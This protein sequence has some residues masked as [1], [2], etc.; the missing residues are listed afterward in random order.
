M[1]I[2]EKEREIFINWA[3][4]YLTPTNKINYRVNTYHIREAFM[5]NYAH[6]FY[7]ENNDVNEI[8]AGMGYRH[9]KN[10]SDIYL[11]WNI[12]SKSPAL[13]QSHGTFSTSSCDLPQDSERYE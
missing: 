10:F 8:L 1:G 4:R 5:T 11:D 13:R 2:S 3:E 12:S 6:G 7:L 9:N